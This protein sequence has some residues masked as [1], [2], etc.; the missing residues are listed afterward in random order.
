MGPGIEW[1]V[2][3]QKWWVRRGGGGGAFKFFFWCF[4]G[5][6]FLVI[7]PSTLVTVFFQL[8]GTFR[9]DYEY[10]IE[11]EYDFRISNQ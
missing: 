3:G 9:S 4:F 10:E 8:I 1:S 6:L 5:V 7:R 2:G 11:Y